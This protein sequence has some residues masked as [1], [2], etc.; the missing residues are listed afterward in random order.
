MDSL[1][2][3]LHDLLKPLVVVAIIIILILTVSGD[4]LGMLL[5]MRLI[6]TGGRLSTPPDIAIYEDVGCTISLSYIDWGSL[7]PGMA[8]NVTMYIRN[9]GSGGTSLSLSTTSWQPANISWYMNLT[10]SYGGRAL[11]PHEVVEATLT[12]WSSSSPEFT[13]YLIAYDVRDFSFDVVINAMS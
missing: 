11:L 10:W 6:G 9:E 13:D 1:G 3:F 8:R 5:S 4:L 2:S 7:Q 12:L